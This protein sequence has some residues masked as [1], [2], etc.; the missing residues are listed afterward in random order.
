MIL[1]EMLG[2]IA[3][4]TEVII[5]T[6]DPKDPYGY[7]PLGDIDYDVDLDE[8]DLALE[9]GEY[10]A[11]KVVAVTPIDEDTLCI[12]ILMED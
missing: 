4:G 8:L 10:L 1:R 5:D 7:L 9:I 3:Y 6:P 12:T 11:C 2:Y